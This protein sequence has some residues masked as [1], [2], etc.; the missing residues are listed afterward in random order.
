MKMKV[1][2]VFITP[3]YIQS[4]LKPELNSQTIKIRLYVHL[5]L[6][7]LPSKFR[8]RSGCGHRDKS[9]FF[10]SDLLMHLGG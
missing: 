10:E 3:L 4:D 2:K 1:P 6:D 9:L 8:V 7:C 5:C